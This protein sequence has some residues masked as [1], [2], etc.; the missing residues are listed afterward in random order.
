MPLR[1]C[2]SGGKQGWKWGE[3]GTCY[4][5]PDAKEKANTQGRAIEASKQ[6]KK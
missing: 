2:Q 6:K 3:E 1:P 4:T 5:G